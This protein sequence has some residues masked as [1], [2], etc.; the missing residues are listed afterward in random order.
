MQG[1]TALGL[2][3]LRGIMEDNFMKK[4]R[5]GLGVIVILTIC[6][7]LVSWS[8]ITHA[9]ME[10]AERILFDFKNTDKQA[11]NFRLEVDWIKAYR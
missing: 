11:G 7:S 1:L 5:K 6:L 3:H 4:A 10:T 9:T 2:C 8:D